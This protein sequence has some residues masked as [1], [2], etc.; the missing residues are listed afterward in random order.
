MKKKFILAVLIALVFLMPSYAGASPVEDFGHIVFETTGWIIGTDG[1]SLPFVADVAPFTYRVTLSD[2]SESPNFGFDFLF[3]AIT[4][5]TET[6]GS[7]IGP[8]QFT[9]TAIP[10]QTYFV[11]VFG[12]GGGDFDTGLFGVEI[13]AIPIPTSLLLFGSGILGLVLLR[14]R[15]H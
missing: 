3:L 11:N 7:I 13:A 12:V 9:F 5:A 4:T 2:L 6:I 10:G 14:L 8:G 1:V 15:K